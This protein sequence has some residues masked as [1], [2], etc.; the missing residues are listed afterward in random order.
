MGG[1]GGEEEKEGGRG[2]EGGRER[3]RRE[4]GREEARGRE[5]GKEEGRGKRERFHNEVHKD[6]LHRG[7][8][9]EVVQFRTDRG[10]KDGADRLVVTDSHLG[11]AL[12][13][14]EVNGAT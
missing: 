2:S 6:I 3:G 8:H 13:R 12:V 11:V 14:L 1:G 10:V 5:E 7:Q 9:E 4:R